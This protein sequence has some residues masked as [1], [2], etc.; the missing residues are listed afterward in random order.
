MMNWMLVQDHII[1]SMIK[2][3]QN[4]NQF[5]LSNKMYFLIVFLFQ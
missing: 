5:A 4:I 1:A 3:I 2:A